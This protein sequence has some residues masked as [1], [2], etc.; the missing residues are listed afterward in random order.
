MY[1]ET[2]SAGEKHENKETSFEK[3]AELMRRMAQEINETVER[4]YDMSR[5]V[6][7]DGRINMEN[8]ST[9]NGG[10]YSTDS[11]AKHKAT[12][13]QDERKHSGS[14]ESITQQRYK[15][16]Y[17]IETEE[18]IMTHHKAEKAKTPSNQAEMAV[19]AL[20]HKILK[21]RFIIVR[22]S[23]FDDYEHGMDNVIIDMETGVLICAFDEVL[24]NP[25]DVG[26]T[27]KKVEKVQ[28]I[29]DRG[30]AEVNY[31]IALTDD[32]KLVRSHVQNV[33]V[34][35]LNLKSDDLTT[36]TQSLS[37]E[38]ISFDERRIFMQLID[39]IE[40]QK[41]IAQKNITTTHPLSHHL[42]RKLTELTPSLLTLREFCEKV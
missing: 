9:E 1:R 30:G 23:E 6:N 16:Q 42:D 39:S 21:G 32:K 38:E 41:N 28:K 7:E 34:F 2:F 19:T 27:S 14:F 36:L 11:V 29:L 18:G 33:P 8:F 13:F 17:G 24:E 3:L 4:E 25:S 12:I 10:I 15:K 5:L 26:K 20:L 22:S 37:K 35:Y 31:G 40:A